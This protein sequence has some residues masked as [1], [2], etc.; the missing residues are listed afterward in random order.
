MAHHIPIQDFHISLS[1]S[2]Q[3]GNAG[4]AYGADLSVSYPITFPTA[5]IQTIAICGYTPGGGAIGYCSVATTSTEYFI[6]RESQ[7]LGTRW[8]AVGR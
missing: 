8:I 1:A 6:L 2:E 3:W 5:V 7:A 4:M